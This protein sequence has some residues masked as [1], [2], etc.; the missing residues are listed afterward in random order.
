MKKIIAAAVAT[1]FVAPAFAADVFVTGDVEF[2]YVNQGGVM[3]GANGDRDFNITGSEEFDGM[4]VKAVLDFEDADVANGTPDAK[5][6]ISG[7]FGTVEFGAGASE[8]SA[9]WEDAAD[10]AEY[11]AGAE[12]SDGFSTETS[13]DYR[14]TLMEGLS[15]AASYGINGA[16]DLTSMAYGLEYSM[17]GYSVAYSTID[18]DSNASAPSSISGSATFGP[19]YVGVERVAN[20]GGTTDNDHTSAGITYTYGPGKLYYESNNYSSDATGTDT[21]AYGISYKMGP[22]N[23]YLG[24]VD[25]DGADNTTAV[26]IEYGF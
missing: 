10:V 19:V 14:G 17:G 9:A 16:E 23:T 22:V 18:V 21:A 24:V 1:A 12:L 25:T 13:V 26:G 6:A 11:G 4:T 8:A 7:D 2:V 15:V 3:S 20:N 5:L